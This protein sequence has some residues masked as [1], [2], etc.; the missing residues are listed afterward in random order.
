MP[1]K[2]FLLLSMQEFKRACASKCVA[3]CKVW[4]ESGF[5]LD[6]EVTKKPQTSTTP[7]YP[8]QNSLRY[9]KGTS[10]SLIVEEVK[11]TM[12]EIGNQDVIY[13]EQGYFLETKPG[14]NP[15][16][17]GEI[18]IRKVFKH[19][20]G[21]KDIQANAHYIK[22]IDPEYEDIPLKRYGVGLTPQ[23]Y[24]NIF[25]HIVSLMMENEL[26]SIRDGIITVHLYLDFWNQSYYGIS[27]DERSTTPKNT[28]AF[29]E[30][31]PANFVNAIVRPTDSDRSE[32]YATIWNVLNLLGVHEIGHRICRYCN[33]KHHAHHLPYY[34]QMGHSTWENTT[35]QFKENTMENF[36]YYFEKSKNTY[37]N[38]IRLP[39]REDL[40]EKRESISKLQKAGLFP[41]ATHSKSLISGKDTVLWPSG[42]DRIYFDERLKRQTQDTTWLK[43]KNPFE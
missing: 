2:D 21:I 33:D 26:K 30:P 28:R 23:C 12:N 36:E 34:R 20:I 16:R 11:I 8:N 24:S 25:T 1:K 19:K 32:M 39:D 7:G 41:P 14:S 42:I 38:S 15:E 17:K 43:G 4:D 18:Y 5:I 40:R 22:Q 27:E 3:S 35:K 37:N 6:V 31:H 29:Y 13:D 9:T 10:F